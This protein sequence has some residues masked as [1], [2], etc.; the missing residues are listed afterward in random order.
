MGGVKHTRRAGRVDPTPPGTRD[1]GTRGCHRID[2]IRANALRSLRLADDNDPGMTTH[3]ADSLLS[4]IRWWVWVSMVVAAATLCVLHPEWTSQHDAPGF[5][6][7]PLPA[8][9]LVPFLAP[10]GQSSAAVAPRLL[11]DSSRTADGTG[12]AA[13]W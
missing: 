7:L 8:I 6:G 1:F 5:A 4:P 13:S 11:A 3:R 9:A 12:P 2:S 10:A